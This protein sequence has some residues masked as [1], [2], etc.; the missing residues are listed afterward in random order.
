MLSLKVHR[1]GR[2]SRA[3]LG[4]VGIAVLATLPGAC[5]TTASN[6]DPADH[7]YRK[8]HPILISD[9]PEVFEI[10]VGM[11]GPAMSAEIDA[12]VQDY[13]RDYLASGTG[14]VTI[15]VPSGSANEMAAGA[16]GRAVHYALVRAGVPRAAITVA[17]YYVGNY[18]KT[19]SVRVAFLKVKA[20]APKCGVWPERM[21]NRT[22]N[23]NAHNFGCAYQ[24]N[25][26]AMVS[27]P[28][29]LIRPRPMDPANGARRANVITTY[30]EKGNTGWDPAPETT[31]L[32]PDSVGGV[33]Q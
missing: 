33:G 28:A 22:D 6:T 12:A 23:A 25:L 20:V 18:E 9:E 3:L 13:V 14:G 26:A 19:A 17:P 16:T 32:N 10:P 15:Q 8:R 5:A 2:S 29:D 21:P 1:P 31:L 30:A 4:A 11:K 27:N 24:Q 7:D